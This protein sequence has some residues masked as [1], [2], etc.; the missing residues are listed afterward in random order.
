MKILSVYVGRC[1]TSRCSTGLPQVEDQLF[2]P[3]TKVSDADS[4]PLG[5]VHIYEA[6]TRRPH[7]NDPGRVFKCV[8]IEMKEKY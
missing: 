5:I 6:S 8:A 2:E 3:E 7:R 4:S 1:A